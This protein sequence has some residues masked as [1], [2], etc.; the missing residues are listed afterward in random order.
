MSALEPTARFDPLGRI[1]TIAGCNDA[2]TIRIEDLPSARVPDHHVV[3]DGDGAV[4]VARDL[5][6]RSDNTDPDVRA[7]RAALRRWAD[8]SLAT[9]AS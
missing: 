8:M 2:I 5:L 9:E 1:L 6:E 4:Q 7:A 3:M